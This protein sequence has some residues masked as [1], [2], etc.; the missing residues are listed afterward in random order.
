[1]YPHKQK[2]TQTHT[3]TNSYRRLCAETAPNGTKFELTKHERNP[4]RQHSEKP[5]YC[6]RIFNGE[7]SYFFH[8]FFV[9]MPGKKR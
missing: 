9:F 7:N 4:K 3:Y 2:F 5:L 6:Y 8:I 1:M